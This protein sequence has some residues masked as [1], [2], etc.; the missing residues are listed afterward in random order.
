MTALKHDLPEEL[1]EWMAHTGEGKVTKLYRHVARREAW[2]VDITRSDGSVL[3][4]FLRLQRGQPQQAPDPQR[5]EREVRVMQ[6]LHQRGI[7]APK[8]YGWHGELKAALLERDPGR[9]DIDKLD[10]PEQQRAIM[11]D[12]MDVLANIHLLNID[13]LGLDDVMQYRPTTARDCAL[14]EVEL[15]ESQWQ[16]FLKDYNDPLTLYALSWLRRF[17]P[18][19]VARVSL[20]Q[21]DTGPVNFMFQGDKVSS[22]ID[23]ETAHFGD[24]LEDLGNIVVREMWNPCGGLK[25]LFKRYEEKSGVP[26]DRFRVQYYAVQQ[27]VRGMIPIHLVSLSVPKRESLAWYLCYRYLGDR[28]TTQMLAAA[29][30]APITPPDLPEECKSKDVISRYTQQTLFEDVLPHIEDAFAQARVKD[31]A[32]LV[33]CSDRKVR[34]GQQLADDEKADLV[35][36]IGTTFD[37]LQ[38]GYVLFKNYLSS[39]GFDDAATINFLTRKA[40]RDEWLHLPA[41]NLYPARSWSELD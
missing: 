7:P 33:A 9:S 14:N 24:P 40:L 30:D 36:L 35:E 20:L 1:V 41:V 27:N 17:A 15:V 10:S 3:E 32:A 38:E 34:F 11:Q 2:V 39:E 21:G 16:F 22:V 8:V 5:L 18:D 12:F 29:M 19:E 37:N 26:Y 28:G 6:L 4:G 13:E 25:G 23:W 31:V